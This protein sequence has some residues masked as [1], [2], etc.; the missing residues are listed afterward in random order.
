MV[1]ITYILII[2]ILIL[3]IIFTFR[4]IIRSI[5]VSNL[6][7]KTVL[8]TGCDSGFGFDLALKCFK[9]GL[10]VFAACLSD[11][12]M[13][14][15]EKEA[16]KLKEKTNGIIHV[17]QMD[18]TK[19]ESVTNGLKFVLSKLPPNRGL[20]AL[21]NNAGIVG[22]TAWDDW[23]IPNDYQQVWEVNTMGMIR[24]TQTFK[25]LIKLEKG[26]RIIFMASTCARVA[27]PTLGPYNVSKYA[28]EAYAD[29][30]RS[31]L[32]M[33][34]VKV[35]ILEPGF[36]KTPLTS[37]ERNL[38]MFEK[39]WLRTTEDVKTDY[40]QNLYEFSK[41]RLLFLIDP[42]NLSSKTHLVV[43][44][45]WHAISSEWP[46]RRY[47]IGN[48]FNFFFLPFSFLPAN[49]QDIFYKLASI[50]AGTPNPQLLINLNKCNEVYRGDDVIQDEH[51]PWMA[52]LLGHAVCTGSVIGRQYIL[53]A[54]HC[55]HAGNGRAIPAESLVVFV[56]SANLS[57]ATPINVERIIL[58]SEYNDRIDD[59]I[60]SVTTYDMAILKLSTPLN[61]SETL[62][63]ICLSR[64]SGLMTSENKVLVAGWGNT[65]PH[66]DS[67]I[68]WKITHPKIP[69]RLQYGQ[70]SLINLNKKAP[71]TISFLFL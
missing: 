62:W 12:G 46:K 9:K 6:Q 43:G 30:I 50:I 40:G 60:G 59:Q 3:F 68:I 21:V 22:N 44:A 11:E 47:Q 27:L 29:T 70:V 64:N 17:F 7:Q 71:I 32:L 23:L 66:C 4:E 13:K 35:C 52:F 55:V 45:Y 8:I 33:F 48:D 36:F 42:K 5:K 65:K 41:K 34:G 26:S 58:R 63:P 51:M 19:E 37:M 1:I 38:A 28:V 18:V 24:V 31:E 14:I 20:H 25:R 54:G 57:K 39:L 15:I 49:I 61:L 53:S 67:S 69:E 10:N 56:G 16:S 2:I